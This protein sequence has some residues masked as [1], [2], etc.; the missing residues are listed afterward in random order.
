MYP[1]AIS[2]MDSRP[3]GYGPRAASMVIHTYMQQTD[4][5]IYAHAHPPSH[6]HTHRK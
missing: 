2:E 1:V 6:T 4:P 5:L 3:V